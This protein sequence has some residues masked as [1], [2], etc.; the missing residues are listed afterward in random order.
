MATHAALSPRTG[1]ALSAAFQAPAS[2]LARPRLLARLAG[3]ERRRLTLVVAD[4]GYGKT[5]LLAQWGAT[6][7]EGTAQAW[8][9]AR[10]TDAVPRTFTR[11]LAAALGEFVAVERPARSLEEA[12]D[13]LAQDVVLALDDVHHLGAAGLPVL[14]LL[15]EHPR[16]HLI[17]AGREMPDLPLARLRIQEQVVE[18]SAADLAF[19]REEIAA[20]D[21]G[22]D[23][24]TLLGQTQGWPA[25]FALVRLGGA[26]HPTATRRDLFDLLAEEVWPRLAPHEREVLQAA[27]VAGVVTADLAAHLLDR[28]TAWPVLDAFTQRGWLARQA[29][30]KHQVHSLFREFVLQR[31]PEPDRMA[32]AERAV[33]WW[34]ARGEAEEAGAASALCSIEVRHRFLVTH[35]SLVSRAGGAA[36]LRSVLDALPFDPEEPAEVTTLRGRLDNLEGRFDEALRWLD[37]AQARAEQSAN[38]R[39]LARSSAY[40]AEIHGHRGEFARSAMA[41]R[42]ALTAIG[43]RDRAGTAELEGILAWALFQL[44]RIDEAFEMLE[45]ARGSFAG[46]GHAQQEAILIRRRGAMHSTRGELGEALRWEQRALLRF[47]QLREP[48]GE[49]NVAMNMGET[50]LRGGRYEEALVQ[51]DGALAIARRHGLTGMAKQIVLVR[52]A[53][54]AALSGA[55]PEVPDTHESEKDLF[56][57][58]VLAARTARRRG[59]LHRAWQEVG[60]ARAL[61][62]ALAPLYRLRLESEEGALRLLERDAAGALRLLEPAVDALWE[63]PLRV[64]SHLPRLHR[65]SA[66]ILA[67]RL[68]GAGADAAILMAWRTEADLAMLWRLEAWAAVPVLELARR[69]R[70]EAGYAATLLEHLGTTPSTGKTGASVRVRILGPFHVERE[71]AVVE[72]EAFGRPQ[73]R[74]LLGYLA[75]HHPRSVPAAELV[76]A[77]WPQAASIEESSLYTT[78]SR[79]RRV[80]G[81]DAVVKDGTG[82]RLGTAV[83]VDAEAFTRALAARPPRWPEI[84]ALYRGE[85]LADLPLAEWCFVTRDTFRSRFVDAAVGAGEAALA[86]RDHAA[87]RQAFERALETDPTCEPAVQGLMRTHVLAGDAPRALR[88]F[89]RFTETLERELGLGPSEETLRLARRLA[90]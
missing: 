18:L 82:Y 43:D 12:L 81:R 83:E 87:S 85:L 32:M 27:A 29:G 4:S 63:G 74:L 54:D 60:A 6:L 26:P 75:M 31:M 68:E 17:L 14:R 40:E 16:L 19:T 80:L 66:R 34:V 73:V 65:A 69:E 78:V 89:R 58:R 41:L 72:D 48:L 52:A 57:W 71:G 23:A 37:A 10:S 59:D 84:S 70:V 21:V 25:A 47:R 22:G 7:P 64:E 67:G 50:L 8:H 9:A 88:L 5:T 28:D 79:L 55:M 56:L 15:L 35:G 61:L 77:L 49:A 13:G 62:P 20:L 42:S 76:E 38:W 33:Q 46:Q 90:G 2:A 24:D 44:G 3:A 36:A 39:M 45:R 51:L 53:V 11:R 86:Q 30:D 1:S